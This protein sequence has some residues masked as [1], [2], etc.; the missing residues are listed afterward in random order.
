MTLCDHIRALLIHKND[1]KLAR[2]VA[3]GDAVQAPTRLHFNCRCLTNGRK[4]R[5]GEAR[6][7]GS[8]QPASALLPQPL[9]SAQL[10]AQPERPGQGSPTA[11]PK[12]LSRQLTA[13][14][15]THTSLP[16]PRTATP[17]AQQPLA[18]LIFFTGS[19]DTTHHTLRVAALPACL[20]M[21]QRRTLSNTGAAMTA[22]V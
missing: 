22:A 5:R 11:L 8:S 20:P 15:R 6:R 1:E 19:T 16:T 17:R 2:D 14:H 10:S 13:P 18:A 9:S 3:L 12:T 7:G 21:E 4:Q